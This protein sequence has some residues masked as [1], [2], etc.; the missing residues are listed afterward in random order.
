V[1]LIVATIAA[2][3]LLLIRGAAVLAIVAVVVIG[4]SL[5]GEVN[6][7]NRSLDIGRALVATQ[8]RLLD[9]IDR[10]TRGGTAVYVGQA[11]L[12]APEI[13]SLAFWNESLTRLV[14]L[15]GEPVYGLIFETK[16]ASN[17]G[18]LTDP[19]RAEYI[20]SDEEV[21]VA[22]QRML[23]RKRWR[24]ERVAGPVRVVAYE[25]GIWQDGWQEELSSYTRFSSR[26]AQAWVRVGLSQEA[27]CVPGQNPRVEI[28]V[29]DLRIRQGVSD[30]EGPLPACS[31]TSERVPVP[32]PP[33][34]VRVHIT[35][36]FI[37]AEVTPGSADTR[38]LG[39]KVTYTYGP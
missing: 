16:I 19:A 14:T 33:F 8:P 37:P 10:A 12:R 26:H 23:S 15:G 30:R 28:S 27:G 3:A 35:P 17:D 21:E 20:V 5:T 34:R 2:G 1:G 24:L 32:P 39:A 29:T 38:H 6:A 31:T 11:K 25:A 22:G 4:W 36:T 7:G 9:W 13:L 18:R